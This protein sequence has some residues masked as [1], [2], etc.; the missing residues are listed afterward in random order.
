M[1]KA[2]PLNRLRDISRQRAIRR[3]TA[4]DRTMEEAE[5]PAE[6]VEWPISR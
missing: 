3:P 5:A 4:A 6:P 1:A 2:I